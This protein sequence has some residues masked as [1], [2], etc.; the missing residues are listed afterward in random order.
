MPEVNM[1]WN[2]LLSIAAGGTVWW[3]RGVNTQ[4]AE[5]RKFISITREEVA[6]DYVTK[7]DVDKDFDKIISRLDRLEN[8][9][10]KLLDLK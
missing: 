9:L 8:K 1:L 7:E 10:D 2:L 3:I 6:R 5:L 4:I